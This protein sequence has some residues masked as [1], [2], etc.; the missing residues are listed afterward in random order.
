MSQAPRFSLIVAASEN[1]AI[2]RANWMPFRQRDDLRQFKALT[3]GHH[4][5]MGRKTYEA[6]G[7]AL[8][9]RTTLVLTRD[10]VWTA[11]GVTRIGNF[12]EARSIATAA[13]DDEIFICGGGEVYRAALSLCTRIYLTRIHTDIEHADTFFNFDPSDGWQLAESRGPMVADAEN[14]YAYSYLRYERSEAKRSGSPELRP[15]TPS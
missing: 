4:L 12:D 9:G 6:I 3:M 2:G 5:V 10:P 13:G 15:L 14:E 7:K 8:P 1:D 11:V